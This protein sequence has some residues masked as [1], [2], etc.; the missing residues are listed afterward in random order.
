MEQAQFQKQKLRD[1]RTELEGCDEA[2]IALAETW[3][4][5]PSARLLAAEKNKYKLSDER[6]LCVDQVKNGIWPVDELERPRV[7][8]PDII[9]EKLH[10]SVTT[11]KS[12]LVTAFIEYCKAVHVLW[13]NEEKEPASIDPIAAMRSY[14]LLIEAQYG[15]DQMHWAISQAC[16]TARS[17]ERMIDMAAD[18]IGEWVS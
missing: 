10:P 6:F 16:I 17:C 1:L 13:V 3:L 15:A 12:E 11:N 18:G 7:F 8:H 4:N 2:V 14:L 9:W 5:S